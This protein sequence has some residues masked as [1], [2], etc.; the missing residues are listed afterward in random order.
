M[1]LRIETADGFSMPPGCYVG[2]KLGGVLKQGRYE[3]HRA[4]HFPA[5]VEPRRNAKIDIY[6]HIG[7]CNVAV[8]P[9]V[10]TVYDVNVADVEKGDMNLKLKVNV[11]MT[12]ETH[13]ERDVHS[14]QVRT[15]A[16][17]YLS[18]FGIEEKLSEVLKMLLKEQPSDPVE[19]IC[20]QLRADGLPPQSQ[21]PVKAAP[22]PQQQPQSQAPAAVKESSAAPAPAVKEAPAAAAA[23]PKTAQ[24]A[25]LTQFP[26]YYKQ[27]VL[28]APPA[29]YMN[30]LHQ[31]FPSPKGET[32]ASPA[33]AAAAPAAAAAPTAGA[34]GD[35]EQRRRELQAMLLKATSDGSL[36]KAL[37]NALGGSQ[38]P[39]TAAEATA[40]KAAD[41][42][43]AAAPASASPTAP[44]LP[45]IPP[46]TAMFFH[47]P[48][49][50]TWLAPNR[51]DADS[52]ASA[53]RLQSIPMM[54]TLGPGALSFG[55]QPGMKF[56]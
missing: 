14:K 48:S 24:K 34:G 15:Q 5:A 21:E 13:K 2:V 31:K 11:N 6:K 17:D 9:E 33:P 42:P 3:P 1:E 10:K 28:R 40:P 47:K 19:F 16:K 30:S 32:S 41:A 51:M 39:A 7:S 25:D 43:A 54:M 56:I 8:D 26:A 22:P 23:G 4:Y 29:S 52:D 12:N 50:A 36:K 53:P 44:A 27:E 20:R 45:S 55:I 49:V 35:L 46:K 37:D 18:K 38:A